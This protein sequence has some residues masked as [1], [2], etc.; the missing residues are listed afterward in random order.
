MSYWGF[1]IRHELFWALVVGVA[2]G[3]AIA[4]AT[5]RPALSV[6]SRRSRRSRDRKW[7][8]FWLWLAAAVAAAAAGMVIPPNLVIFTPP[9]AYTAAAGFILAAAALRFPRAA[10]IPIAV[11]LVLAASGGGLLVR[12]WTPV[13]DTRVLAEFV[14]LALEEDRMSVEVEIDPDRA[15]SPETSVVQI[16]DRNLT[17]RALLHEP[18]PYLFL[19]GASSFIEL[20]EP[21]AVAPPGP[22]AWLGELGLLGKRSTEARV[23]SLNLLQRYELL[24][25][26]DPDRP[27]L[28]VRIR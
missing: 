12:S 5:R 4:D 11:L 25:R 19:L 27:I 9:A 23:E 21:V 6:R 26:P 3:G 17:V 14:V 20:A 15:A 22:P 24:A 28:L 16:P 18:S 8:R 10:G 7:A 13:R 1:L 2:L